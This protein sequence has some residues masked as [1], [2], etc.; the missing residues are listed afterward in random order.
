MTL[1]HA[2]VLYAL[3]WA[4]F[5]AGH[6]LL[7]EPAVKA[8]LKPLLG[9]G[10]RL[11]YNLFAA[12]HLAAVVAVGR[13]AFA[14]TAPFALPPWTA[15]PMTAVQIAGAL[16]LAI[17]LRAY[18]LG[19]FAGVTQIKNARAGKSEP[20][21]EPLRTEGPHRFVRHPLYA[22]LLLI[23]WGR[24]ADPFDLATALWASVYLGVGI[25]FEERKLVALYGAA[26][27]EYRR[28]VPALI[29]WKGRAL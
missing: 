6:S 23:L 26:Y 21:D 15:L 16:V 28:R 8:R 14:G 17:A 5:G 20:E 3:A 25:A 29:P 13:W 7:A 10:Y 1:W 12:L 19:R 11:T 27:V 2:Y 4:S 22:G 24:I 18:D 9:A